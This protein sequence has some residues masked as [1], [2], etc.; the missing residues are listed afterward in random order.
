[1]R[2]LLI[3][4]GAY[5]L[6]IAALVVTFWLEKRTVPAEYHRQLLQHTNGYGHN[7]ARGAHLAADPGSLDAAGDN[8]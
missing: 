3:V 8:R 6:T 4:H 5:G 2:R 7:V 1:M